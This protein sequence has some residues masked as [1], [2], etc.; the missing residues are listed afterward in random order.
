[1]LPATRQCDGLQRTVAT[2]EKMQAPRERMEKKRRNSRV[3]VEAVS[4]PE[5]NETIK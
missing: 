2:E 5:T 4:N 3:D 1:M